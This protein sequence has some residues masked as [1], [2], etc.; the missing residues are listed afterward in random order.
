MKPWII[1]TIMIIGAMLFIFGGIMAYSFSSW[2]LIFFK[3][4]F[5]R[6]VIIFSIISLLG[7]II[8][9]FGI[10]KLV[11]SKRGKI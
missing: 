1:F 6:D 2:N 3:V 8:L 7:L 10:V 4:T 9:I 5:W 11:R